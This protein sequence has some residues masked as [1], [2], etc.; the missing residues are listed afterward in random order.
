MNLVSTRL[1]EHQTTTTNDQIHALENRSNNVLYSFM[2]LPKWVPN[3]L[4]TLA[5]I[6]EKIEDHDEL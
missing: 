5:I 4:S 3:T 1:T 2:A 6:G